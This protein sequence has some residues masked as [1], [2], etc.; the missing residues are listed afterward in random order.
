LEKYIYEPVREKFRIDYDL[1]FAAKQVQLIF[2][3]SPFKY[4]PSAGHAS[5]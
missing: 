5:I 1:I 3:S 2:I 4:L